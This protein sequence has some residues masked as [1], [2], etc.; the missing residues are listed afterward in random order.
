MLLMG[1]LAPL[2]QLNGDVPW[3]CVLTP[4]DVFIKISAD[5]L[6]P[7]LEKIFHEILR[8]RQIKANEQGLELLLSAVG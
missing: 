4:S 5:G 1:F 6:T 2:E 8:A 3:L 7:H